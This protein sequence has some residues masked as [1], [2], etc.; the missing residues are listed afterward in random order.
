MIRILFFA[1]VREEVGQARL[2][3]PLPA[4]IT[5]LGTLRDHLAAQGEGWSYL[6]RCPNLRT[7]LNQ[8]LAPPETPLRE[9]DEVAFF[10]PV[11][12]G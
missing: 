1:R 11:T 5:T 6:S 12:G 3:M 8:E 4:G 2:E 9:G 10:P 7:A